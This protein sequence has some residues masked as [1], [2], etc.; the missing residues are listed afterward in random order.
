MASTKTTAASLS[1]YAA[2]PSGRIAYLI[3]HYLIPLAI[4][5]GALISS[6]M[7]PSLYPQTSGRVLPVH[8]LETPIPAGQTLAQTALKLADEPAHFTRYRPPGAAWFLFDLPTPATEQTDRL[9]LPTPSAT[10]LACWSADGQSPGQAIGQAGRTAHEGAIRPVQQGFTIDVADLQRPA[11]ILCTVDIA[12]AD[13]VSIGLW[14]HADLTAYFSRLSRGIGVLE[15]GLMTLALFLVVIALTTREWTYVLL[16]AWLIGN[17]RLGAWALGWDIQWL[18][19][20]IPATTMPMVRKLTVAAYYF[21]TYNLFTQLFSSSLSAVSRRR[22]L[23][24]GAWSGLMLLVAA[25]MLPYVWF[26]PIMFL[27]AWLGTGLIAVNLV[28]ALVRMHSRVWLWYIIGLCLALVIMLGGVVLVTMGE[29]GR[30]DPFIGAI[31]LLL[32]NLMVALAV[33]EHTREERRIH[34][35]ARNELIAADRLMPF[36][37]FTLDSANLFEHMNDT[38]RR[39][40]G[41]DPQ[42]DTEAENGTTIRW[43]DY[44]EAQDWA[45]I[46]R[47]T[48]LGEEVEIRLHSRLSEPGPVRSFLLRATL[49]GSHVE[50]SI[51]DISARAEMIRKLGL[52]ADRDP[53]T[54]AYTRR[55]IEAQMDRSIT[56]LANEGTPCALAYLNL[57]H[58]KRINDMFGHTAGEE[59]LKIVSERVRYALSENQQLGRV[60]SDEFVILFPNMQARDAQHICKDIIES[61]NSAALNVGKRFFQLKSAMGVIDI[62]KRMNA[63]DAISAA[64]RA[65][66]EARKQHTDIVLYEDNASEL[67]EHIEELRL[68]DQLDGSSAPRDIYLEMQPIMSL[69]HPLQTLNFEVLLRVRNSAD[70]HIS[71]PKIIQA[72]EE[73]GMISIIDKWVFSA[74]LE[75]VARHRD[76]LLRTEVININ[77][78]GV[79]LNDDKFIDMLFNVLNSHPQFTRKLCVEITEGVALLDLERTRQFMRRL[80]RMGARVALDDFGAGY[81]SFSYLKELPADIIKIDGSLICDMLASKANVAIVATIV[82]LA[83]NLGMECIAEWVEDIP[84]MQA[85]ADM[86]VDSVQGY[87]ISEARPPSEMLASTTI[88]NLVKRPEA[89]AFIESLSGKRLDEPVGQD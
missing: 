79:S 30:V 86:G 23:A 43:T 6:L 78:S 34:S 38:M 74:T 5:L 49:A 85:L 64:S 4:V 45:Q 12:L 50:G 76:K 11:S 32:A 15:G 1:T 39:M 21:L 55:G 89:R 17:M 40:L 65:C 53:L 69:R 8:M 63:K 87:V 60:G 72:A 47:S 84:T 82:D 33:A 56:A 27:A 14:Q 81:T 83:H 9:Y 10:N 7:L 16:A 61:L 28:Y 25:L 13:T 68:F 20:E 57:D 73:N 88:L 71:T 46:A 36:G 24:T 52:L 18:G 66:R 59:I 77:L 2:T 31:V 44:F 58:M 62:D 26:Q 29:E 22:L 35:R 70:T 80:Q 37:L 19:I 67:F 51:Q 48:E 3:S 54:D 42:G 75:W 41:L